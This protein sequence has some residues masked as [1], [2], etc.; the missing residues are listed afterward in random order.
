MTGSDAQDW[1]LEVSIRDEPTKAAHHLLDALRGPGAA[2]RLESDVPAAVV[3][4][5]DGNTFF[6]YAS[7]EAHIRS[8]RDAVAA[9]L[10]R[11]DIAASVRT[12]TWDDSIDEWRQTDPPL[13]GNAKTAAGVVDRDARALETRTLVATAGRAV[14]IDFETTMTNAARSLGLQCTISEHPHLLASQVA[15]TLTGPH[16]KIDEFAEEL[17]VEGWPT[18]RTDVAIMAS[19]L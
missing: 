5:H 11:D 4:T 7:D 14:R 15:F 8:V 9:V 19:P 17:V 1:R 18:I 3:M 6:S 13:T 12:S 2:R 10:A 16:H